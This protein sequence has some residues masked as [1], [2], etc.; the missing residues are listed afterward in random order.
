MTGNYRVDGHEGVT[1]RVHDQT[2]NATT[3]ITSTRRTAL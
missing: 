3:T 2:L 1:V